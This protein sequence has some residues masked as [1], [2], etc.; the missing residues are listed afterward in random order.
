MKACEVKGWPVHTIVRSETVVKDG[1][2]MGQKMARQIFAEAEVEL[3]CE[4][5]KADGFSRLI[6][7]VK[8]IK[9]KGRLVCY[10]LMVFFDMWLLLSVLIS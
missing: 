8:T 3:G 5:V 9:T 4:V 10:L 6:G 1:E 2:V 7:G